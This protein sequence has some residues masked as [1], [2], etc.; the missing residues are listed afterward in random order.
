M[1]DNLASG[2]SSY[3][4]AA[5]GSPLAIAGTV[6]SITRLFEPH[7]SVIGNY[8]GFIDMQIGAVFLVG[9][10]RDVTADDNDHQGRPLMAVRK[11]LAL[12]GYMK[13]LD[14]T[15]EDVIATREELR[16]IRGYLESGFYY[17]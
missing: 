1:I 7:M 5:T 13:V 9:I 16:A 2:A 11:P 17:E 14:G 6:S 8:G 12:G 15:V 4:E 10:F 3:V